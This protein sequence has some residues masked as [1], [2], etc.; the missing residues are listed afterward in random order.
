MDGG[1]RKM[2]SVKIRKERLESIEEAG[3]PLS[4]DIRGVESPGV[5]TTKNLL[6]IKFHC[7]SSRWYSIPDQTK[8]LVINDFLLLYWQVHVA[9][10]PGIP[11]LSTSWLSKS[12][13]L[14][15]L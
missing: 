14:L 1:S 15:V 8:A 10:F 11:L 6:S 2:M 7:A 5:L 4:A 13:V 12:M 9:A 3:H